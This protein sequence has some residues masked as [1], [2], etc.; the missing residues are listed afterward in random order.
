VND[1]FHGYTLKH[2]IFQT[3]DVPGAV[4]TAPE[5]LNESDDMVG[6]FIG[7]DGVQ[8]GFLK[9]GDVFTSL[10]FPGAVGTTF[11][12]QVND[13]GTIV[14]I[15]IDD[16]HVTHSFS[17]DPL[18]GANQDGNGNNSTPAIKTIQTQSCSASRQV[19]PEQIRNPR[20]CP[21]TN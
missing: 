4:G 13:P 20:A 12:F 21:A 19:D 8:H 3:I 7:Q 9:R 6:L 5:G 1:N 15:Y 14:G 10:D 11:P 16:Q 2:G 18:P 17:A